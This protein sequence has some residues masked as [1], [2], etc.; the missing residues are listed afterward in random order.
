MQGSLSEFHLG[1]LRGRK[2]LAEAG[3]K[4]PGFN[5]GHMAAAFYK[6]ILKETIYSL[7][8]AFAPLSRCPREAQWI[9]DRNLTAL[10]Q[11]TPT[12]WSRV[13]HV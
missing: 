6:H 8:T 10:G 1:K 3:R 12:L 5:P 2:P 11:V 13:C 9:I 4:R 7:Q